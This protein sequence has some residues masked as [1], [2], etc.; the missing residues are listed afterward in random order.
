M[1]ES[2]ATLIHIVLIVYYERWLSSQT[3]DNRLFN[4]L[5][6]SSKS[7]FERTYR[8]ISSNENKNFKVLPAIPLFVQFWTHFGLFILFFF[9]YLNEWLDWISEF[10]GIIEK[11]YSDQDI[12]SSYFVSFYRR[13]IHRRVYDCVHRPISGVPGV[14]T[15]VLE[16]NFSPGMKSFTLSGTSKEL[17]NIASYNYLGFAQNQGPCADSVEK[18]IRDCGVSPSCSPSISRSKLLRKTER[19]VA[20]FLGKEDSMIASM[21][22]A[23][24]ST[25]IPSLV[26][27][28]ALILSDSLNHA[29]SITGARL[30]GAKIWV[31]QHNDMRNLERLLVKAMIEGQTD[32]QKPWTKIL[33]LVEGLYSMEGTFCDLPGLIALKRKYK[34]YLFVDEAYSIGILGPKGKGICDHYGIDPSEVDVLMGTFSKSFGASGGYIASSK[35]T[36]DHLRIYS[37]SSVYAE[38]VSFPVLQQINSSLSIIAGK[39]GS[40]DGRER[41]QAIQRNSVYL[42]R[43]LKKLGFIIYGDEGSPVIPLIVPEPGQ[44]LAFSRECYQKGLAVAIVS[45][46][47]T[48]IN[49]SR[50]RLCVSAALTQKDLDFIVHQLDVIGDRLQ[51]KYMK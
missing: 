23:T 49:K 21:G 41:I 42:S 40:N 9:G 38:S 48:P 6:S 45:F 50:V 5:F 39:D 32:S 1:D 2:I 26:C 30:S 34:F 35:E 43:S 17:V 19:L 14:H 11:Q 3:T 44:L 31:F 47:A 20:G 37:H 16:R 18:V 51:L 8:W 4:S 22:F 13:R 27:E 28:G 25:T 29:S 15:K 36:I 24:N 7:S 12:V 10:L 46:P 33:V